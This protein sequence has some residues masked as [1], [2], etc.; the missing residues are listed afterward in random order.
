MSGS[1]QDFV[2]A[3]Y[4]PRAQDYVS[5][6]VH[7]AG[8][9][10]DHIEDVLRGRGLARVLDLGCGG[11]HVSYRAAPHVGE[12]VACDVTPAMLEAVAAEARARGLA[13]IR[14]QLAP[15]E[16]LPF[17][18]ATFDAVLCRFSVHHWHD[19]EAGLRQARRVTKPGGLAIIVDTIAAADR[20]LDTYLQA[21]ELLRDVSHVRNYSMAEW[22]GA[23]SRA[24]F[25]LT[26]VA[27]RG[28]R[29]EFPIWIART[30]PPA[31][32]VEAIR[33]L[34]R[35]AP[36]AVRRHFAIGEDGSFDLH[37]AL[38]ELYAA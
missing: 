1:Q 27:V 7:S 25:E 14:T 33:S 9:D 13:N 35:G 2:A 16:N 37:G 30:H 17:A 28:L 26:G 12:V 10:L 34:Q 15:A 11:G 6:A 18:D 24:G 4:A 21:I 38:F 23:L 5:S 8:A 32:H 29:M 20:V 36:E 3:Q 31:S 19:M 22:V